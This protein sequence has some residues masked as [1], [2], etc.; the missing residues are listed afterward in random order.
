MG[1]G[2]AGRAS[3]HPYTCSAPTQAVTEAE[4]FLCFS[5]EEQTILK[6]QNG[7]EWREVF[8]AA[9]APDVM[10]GAGTG[11]GSPEPTCLKPKLY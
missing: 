1:V 6:S 9:W 4:A 3:F 7:E 2:W 11:L 5:G 10:G 8:L